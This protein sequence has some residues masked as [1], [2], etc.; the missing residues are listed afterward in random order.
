MIIKLKYGKTNTYFVRGTSGGLLVDTDYAGTLPAFYKSLKMNNISVSDIAYFLATHYHPDHI[1]LAGELMKL[2]IKLLLIDIQCNYV[3]FADN[4]FARDKHL[5]YEP[6]DEKD[7]I[8]ITCEESRDHLAKI[9]IKGEIIPIKS[10]SDDSIA[11]I[12]DN[13]DCIVG[14]LEPI[15][16]L[17]S[18]EDNMALKSDWKH[19]M[20]HKPKKIYYSHIN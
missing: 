16:Y 4:I 5:L 18:Y 3:H 12:L 7:A 9:G 2:G 20:N 19:I 11:L 6:V 17:D 13:G 14:D 8:V 10:H 15:E 1:G